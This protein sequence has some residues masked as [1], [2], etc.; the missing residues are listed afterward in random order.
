[1]A[2]RDNDRNFEGAI[3]LTQCL[4]RDFVDLE[5]PNP[6]RLHIGQRMVK[7]L[8]GMEN[9]QDRL[10]E[11]LRQAYTAPGHDNLTVVNIRDWHDQADPAQADELNFF[12]PHCL[13]DTRGAEFIDGLKE[14]APTGDIQP[15]DS[16]YI[17]DFVETNLVQVIDQITG[18]HVDRWR[19][20]VIGVY[21]SIKVELDVILLRT[22]LHVPAGQVAVCGNLCG[23]A[24]L[25]RHYASLDKMGT[26]YGATI[27]NTGDLAR[28]PHEVAAFGRWLGLQG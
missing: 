7:R 26:V 10:G 6:N 8:R 9:G 3:L 19:F 21:T 4:Q 20:G 25:D 5:P 28:A 16:I 2:Y 1:M 23:D 24:Y 18:G 22:Q 17:N 13:A 27:F 14:L 15:I 11:F 12:G